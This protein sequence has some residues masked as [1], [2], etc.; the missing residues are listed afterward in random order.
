MKRL[1]HS[2]L[3]NKLP[4][5]AGI[6]KISYTHITGCI[7]LTGMPNISH[8][9]LPNHSSGKEPTTT[10]MLTQLRCKILFIIFYFD[11]KYTKGKNIAIV[12]I[13]AISVLCSDILI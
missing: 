7:S 6:Y 13:K 11:P 10:L 9:S 2:K 3:R 4:I 8:T 1:M 5:T 12:A